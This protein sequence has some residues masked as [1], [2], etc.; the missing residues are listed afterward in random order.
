MSSTGFYNSNKYRHYPFIPG[1]ACE[2]GDSAIVDF[3]CLFFAWDNDYDPT[4]HTVYLDRVRRPASGDIEIYVR[5]TAPG[6]A[7]DVLLFVFPAAASDYSV[8]YVREQA[9]PSAG[10]LASSA[11]SGTAEELS[12]VDACGESPRWQGY[13]VIGDVAALHAIL[14]GV[15]SGSLAT[16][17]STSIF[18]HALVRNLANSRVRFMGVANKDRTRSAAPAGCREFCWEEAVQDVYVVASCLY[19]HIRLREGYNTLIDQSDAGNSLTIHGR[20]GAGRGE[21]YSEIP[22]Y[23]GESGPLNRDGDLGGA[24]ICCNTVRSLNGVAGRLMRLNVGAGVELT[25]LPDEHKL[26]L[27]FSMRGLAYQPVLP[28]TEPVE[29]IAGNEDPCECGPTLPTITTTTTTTTTST[30][31][32]TPV[33]GS[34]CTVISDVYYNGSNYTVE[35]SWTPL[36]PVAPNIIV[37][38][39]LNGTT[40]FNATLAFNT[41]SA[42]VNLPGVVG[43]TYY[44]RVVQ[45]DIAD[46]PLCYGAVYGPFET[47]N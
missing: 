14:D 24:L 18:E 19:G 31:T 3:G 13:L 36:D 37:Q 33:P 47:T 21:P 43:T 6:L 12:A 25:E 41:G 2:M 11:F 32:T 7:D 26:V 5:T 44:L 17:A 22:L 27:N 45:S 23:A 10:N 46:E 15:E 8:Q 30:T 39:S 29:E 34:G 35:Y 42:T 16:I 4:T 40:W 28:A 1:C 38:R 9:M 20:V